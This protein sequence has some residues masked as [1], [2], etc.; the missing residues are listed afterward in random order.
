MTEEW[1]AERGELNSG[2]EMNSAEH[3]A[4]LGFATARPWRGKGAPE[5]ASPTSLSSRLDECLAQV[6]SLVQ[7]RAAPEGAQK[8]PARIEFSAKLESGSFCV[9]HS[10]PRGI[11]IPQDDIPKFGDEEN[12]TRGG[13]VNAGLTTWCVHSWPWTQGRISMMALCCSVHHD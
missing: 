2:P 3:P 5:A 11:R 9:V 1:H 12:A 4:A 8:F 7:A 6:A 10:W 13:G